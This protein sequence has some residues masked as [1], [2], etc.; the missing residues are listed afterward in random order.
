MESGEFAMI[1]CEA[2]IRRVGSAVA[3]AAE[4]I[5]YGV[6]TTQKTLVHIESCRHIHLQFPAI[7]F[8]Q[9]GCM[10]SLFSHLD[11]C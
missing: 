10:F 5:Q 3:I 8:V 11:I 4:F 2:T 7:S 9:F 6:R 1:L